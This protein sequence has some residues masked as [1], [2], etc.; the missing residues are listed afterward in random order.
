VLAAGTY[1][2]SACFQGGGGETKLQLF[3]T[4]GDKTEPVDVANTGWQQRTQPAIAAI[5][6]AGVS[7]TV[8][9]KLD[10]PAGTWGFVDDFELTKSG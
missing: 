1:T 3:A 2:L 7:S 5:A 8:G 4:W 6:I 10:A 9:V